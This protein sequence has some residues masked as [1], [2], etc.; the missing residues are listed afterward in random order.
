MATDPSVS[1][2][3]YRAVVRFCVL[4]G[5]EN[6]V[7]SEQL[8]EAYG[9]NA[10]AESTVRKWARQFRLGRESVEDDPRSGRPRIDGLPEKIED[11]L[12]SQPF[13]STWDIAN[14]L[15]ISQKTAYNVLVRDLHMH[16]FVS[17][18]VPHELTAT[19]KADR[20]RLSRALLHELGTGDSHDIITGDESWFYLNY[21]P[22]GCWARK[23]Q[24]VPVHVRPGIWTQ[25]FM[26]T[27]FWG[28]RG[29]YLIDVL[30][31]GMNFNSTYACT[32]LDKLATSLNE[33]T[34]G[35]GLSGMRFHWDNARPHTS[36]TTRAKLQDLK[37]H[38][39]QHPPYSPDIAPSD[40]FLFGFIKA[41]LK[42]T[43]FYSSEALVHR[44]T[45]IVQG[46]PT[47]TL[48]SVFENWKERL[49]CVSESD[50]GYYL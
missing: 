47:A 10:P 4:R 25:K 42:G 13:A 31:H 43:S 9:S 41:H 3:E 39:L 15:G 45:E 34:S 1:K 50:G 14:E 26:L 29:F 38:V 48:S 19:N 12:D 17:R 27:I 49:R 18:W 6:R 37:V 7:I 46:I 30:P 5:L 24:D 2:E 8:V 21:S 35:K 22:D 23:S 16:K 36:S 11:L 28:I 40:F 20:I 44:V 32:L 33:F